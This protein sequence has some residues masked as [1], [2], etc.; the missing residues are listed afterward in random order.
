MRDNTWLSEPWSKIPQWHVS[1]LRK[2]K[3]Y[4]NHVTGRTTTYSKPVPLSVTSPG[5]HLY[6][7]NKRTQLYICV[8]S[9]T[10]TH[11]WSITEKQIPV[12]HHSSMEHSI[13]LT[14]VVSPE[15]YISSVPLSIVFRRGSG[16]TGLPRCICVSH[17]ALLHAT[18]TLSDLWQ[19]GASERL[20]NSEQ[21]GSEHISW[22]FCAELWALFLSSEIH[23]S[24]E[25]W[26][27][28]WKQQIER[29]TDGCLWLYQGCY[30]R[31]L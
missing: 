9:I 19:R 14:A 29:Y 23:Y 25:Y 28:G 24:T 3:Q 5:A 12:Y 2:R 4:L 16:S 11:L 1:A 30:I 8:F 18:V 27:R 21:V 26:I 15:W 10:H 20:C 31:L 22:L 13:Y 17:K 6:I 7:H